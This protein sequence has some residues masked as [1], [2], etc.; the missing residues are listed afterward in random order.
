[1]LGD[2]SDFGP[3][4]LLGSLVVNAASSRFA[5]NA[6]DDSLRIGLKL[7]NSQTG[8]SEVRAYTDFRFLGG[9]AAAAVGQF[10]ENPI[11][12]RVGHDTAVGLLGSFVATEMV[13]AKAVKRA[14]DAAAAAAVQQIPA[15][16]P[17]TAAPGGAKNYAYGW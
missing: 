11:A 9:V 14:S 5:V 8:A 1:M 3:L 7:K 2:T 6:T 10:M 12:R 4:D 15:Q 16:P 13:R 17:V